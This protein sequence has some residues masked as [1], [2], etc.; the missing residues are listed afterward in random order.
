[1]YIKLR[2][3][4]I[5]GCNQSGCGHGMQWVSFGAAHSSGVLEQR[6]RGEHTVTV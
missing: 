1:M 5:V 3:Q 4:T 2:N 6:T